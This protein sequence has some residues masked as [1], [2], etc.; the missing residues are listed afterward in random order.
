MY[1]Q[2][3]RH[4]NNIGIAKTWLNDKP[5]D[6]FQ[7]DG[8]NLEL[9]NRDNN[10]G[11]GVWLYVDDK[12]DYSICHDLNKMKHPDKTETLAGVTRIT[13]FKLL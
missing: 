8:Y 3:T 11:G 5:H 4:L 13:T 12:I 6:Y 2:C 9:Q 1:F 7:L 10:R